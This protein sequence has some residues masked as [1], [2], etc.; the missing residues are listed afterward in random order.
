MQ[1]VRCNGSDT[2][3]RLQVFRRKGSDAT[4]QTHDIKP[5]SAKA[6]WHK[7]HIIHKITKVRGPT[8]Y[9]AYI[10]NLV[11]RFLCFGGLYMVSCFIIK[12]N[13][14]S[15]FVYININ[16]ILK[17][18][19]AGLDPVSSGPQPLTL[20]TTLYRHGNNSNISILPFVL[21]TLTK[22]NSTYQ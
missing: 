19:I 6:S 8:Q 1:Q 3:C 5:K 4:D 12:T 22:N 13:I 14:T 11:H 18:Q 21:G 2:M 15:F 17:M 16:K 10:L 7:Q 20:P 9:S